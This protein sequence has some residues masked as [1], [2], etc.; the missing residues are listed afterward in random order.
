MKW[1]TNEPMID[2]RGYLIERD[3]NI[4]LD[5]A[6]KW[7]DRDYALILTHWLTGRRVS[8]IVRGT[9]G[10]GIRVKDI[11]FDNKN[12]TYNILKKKKPK[13]VTLPANPFLLD[14][15]DNYIK[16]N[17][18]D[19]E[20]FIFP[21]TRQRAFQIIKRHAKMSGVTTAS[22][23]VPSS[24]K[25]RHTFAIEIMRQENARPEDMIQLKELL[26]HSSINITM[27]YLLFGDTRARELVKNLNTESDKKDDS[28]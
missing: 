10:T 20:Y 15:L 16:R 11:D 23:K 1:N 7:S 3:I 25:F 17:R 8:E 18:L 19:P 14:V 9:K 27:F 13:R 5:E 6:K 28:N 24:H 12:I 22:G 4:L 21:I 26:Q 2:K